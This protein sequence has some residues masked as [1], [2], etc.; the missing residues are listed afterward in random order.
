MRSLYNIPNH[1]TDFKN[2]NAFE[3]QKDWRIQKRLSIRDKKLSED[4][5]KLIGDDARNYYSG[6]GV[7]A[8]K[9]KYWLLLFPICIVLAILSL[10]FLF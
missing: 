9:G 1:H 7:R 2:N 4:Q 8:L 6:I 5:L 3:K 10:A